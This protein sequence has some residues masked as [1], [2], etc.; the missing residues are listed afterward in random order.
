MI[1]PSSGQVGDL[2]DLKRAEVRRLETMAAAGS[3]PRARLEQAQAELADAEDEAVLR[4]SLYGAIRVEDFTKAE[5]DA[6]VDA[7]RRLVERQ[8]LRIQRTE[9][10]VLEGVV[11]RAFL[12]AMRDDLVFR[13]RALTLAEQRAHLVE[14]LAQQAELERELASDEPGPVHYSRGRLAERY[15]GEGAFTTSD[16]ARVAAAFR[17]EFGR[18]LPVSAFGATAFH[19]AMGFDHRDR[20][21]IALNPDQREGVWL[22]SFLKRE[23]I[24]YFAFRAA[25]AGSATAP[26]IHVGPP[27]MRLR[28]AKLSATC[29]RNCGS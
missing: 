22:R 17:R 21:D 25:I 2:A 19:R 3:I 28:Q 12:S 15:D 5:A 26:H 13:N 14:E 24:P 9:Q 29:Q 7:A 20:V 23:R 10:L 4:R 6:M 1:L 11:A 8:E 27:S 16:Y 18:D